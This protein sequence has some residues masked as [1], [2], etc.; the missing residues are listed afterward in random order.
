MQQYLAVDIGASSGRHMLGW[1]EDGRIRL[2]EVYRFEN[3]MVPQGGQLCWDV[4]ALYGHVLAGMAAARQ[5]GAAPVSMGIDTWAVDYL[6]VDE[7]GARLGPAVAYRDKRTEG[8]DA[9]V[10]KLLS[11]EE[12]YR[13]T[14]IQKLAFNT[15]YQLMAQKKQ[16]P[17]ALERAHRFLMMPDYLHC[18]LTG[19]MRN[20]YTNATSTALVD[21]AAKS[22]SAP[23]L[24]KLG[25]PARLFGPPAMPGTVLGPLVGQAAQAAGCPCRV[26][27]PATHDTGSA[28]L[29]VPARDDNAVTLSSGTW[30][31]LGTES[32]HPVISSQ[33]LAANFTN[34][35]G[36]NYRFRVL[37]NIMGLWMIQSV[38]RELG[39]KQ[40]YAEL[41]ALARENAGFAG[42]IDVNDDAF[43]APASMIEAVKD[44]CR[45][46]GQPVP[47]NTGQL[48][49]CI[50]TSLADCY[51]KAIASLETI[52]GRR[53]TSV[54]IVGGGSKDGYLN[55][56]TANATGLVV[57]AGPTEGTVIGNL[58]VQMIAAGEFESLAAARRAVA[59]S[60]DVKEHQPAGT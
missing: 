52:M 26:V 54:N 17:Q 59:Q 56:L 46:S 45:Q 11:F 25:I 36:Y 38:R 43:L 57:Y 55:Q 12:L 29:A 32:L 48:M 9:E 24:E 41:E 42:R 7:A 16:D 22:W 5:A 39:K 35:G 58:M 20:E 44:A 47:Q 60:F 23:L 49:Q 51:K 53:F 14:G 15:I 10:E 3:G 13:L 21:A 4:D 8:M 31:L 1:V 50:Y 2:E 30:S 6:L 40:S 37:K 28:F 33:G 18:R 27:L 19:V 34:E